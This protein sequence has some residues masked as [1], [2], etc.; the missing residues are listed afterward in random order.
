VSSSTAQHSTQ[1][2]A[3]ARVRG[4]VDWRAWAA[5][6]IG[7]CFSCLPHL[8]SAHTR[9][10]TDRQLRSVR[11]GTLRQACRS[12]SGHWWVLVWDGYAGWSQAGRQDWLVGGV[13]GRAG[14]WQ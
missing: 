11:S 1:Q 7:C 9:A 13:Q 12:D 4:G 5:G 3:Q 14:Q 2:A 6:E 8:L 10:Q